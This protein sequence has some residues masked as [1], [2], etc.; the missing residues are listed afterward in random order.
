M[1]Y[2]S[3]GYTYTVR[4]VPSSN[5]LSWFWNYTIKSENN[6][7]YSDMSTVHTVNSF[8]VQIMGFIKQ[9]DAR[10]NVNNSGMGNCLSESAAE[11]HSNL[12]FLSHQVNTNLL[13]Y[14]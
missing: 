2:L 14:F 3:E 10:R 7:L 1:P 6:P 8:D 5:T 12:V 11:Y 4:N 9:R 13:L